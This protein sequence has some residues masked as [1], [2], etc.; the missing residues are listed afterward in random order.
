MANKTHKILVVDDEAAMTR[1]LQTTLVAAGFTVATASSGTEAL[2]KLES[3]G[4]DLVITDIQMAEGDGIWLSQQIKVNPKFKTLPMILLSA[5][6]AEETDGEGLQKGDI[7]MPKPF[8]NVRIVKKV[9]DL[10]A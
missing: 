9:Q 5:L 3:E 4:A 2:K 6:V 7:Y 10:L 1:V 8:D